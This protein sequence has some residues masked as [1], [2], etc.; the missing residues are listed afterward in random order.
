MQIYVAWSKHTAGFFDGVLFERRPRPKSTNNKT[1][2]EIIYWLVRD[3]EWM[4]LFAEKKNHQT[5]KTSLLEIGFQRNFTNTLVDSNG[6]IVVVE[7]YF[8]Q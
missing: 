7:S 4:K 6:V 2:N 3:I 8:S 5:F 1:I